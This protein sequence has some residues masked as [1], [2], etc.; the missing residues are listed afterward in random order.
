MLRG[1]DL[2][3]R[4]EKLMRR[5]EFLS[6]AIAASA[7][8]TGEAMGQ[9]KAG[10]AREFYELRRYHLQSGPQTKQM[11]VYLAEALIPAMNRLGVKTVGAFSLTYG[12]ETPSMYVLLPS[13]ELET[14]VTSDQ[15]LAK[16][17][18]FMRAAAPFWGA[19]STAPAFLRMESKLMLAFEGW[20]KLVVPEAVAKKEKRIYQ[21]R[22]YESATDAAHARK[23]E[24]MNSGETEAF[25]N[26]G[27]TQVFYGNTLI[28][29]SMPNLTYM[30]SFP[31]LAAMDAGWNR[32]RIDPTWKKLSGLVRYNFEASVSNISNLVLTPTD[33]SQ[34]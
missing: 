14:L 8:I 29:P 33:Y 10:K 2:D 12:P 31:D 4:Q 16:D 7:A 32:F 25:R 21:M 30:L 11:D 28:G 19:P 27:C 22:T 17:E 24:M 1:R 34:I 18:A 26:S 23:V 20:P 5:R 9:G 6:G 15:M 3:E 13:M